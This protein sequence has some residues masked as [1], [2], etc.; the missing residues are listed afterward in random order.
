MEN[1]HENDATSIGCEAISKFAVSRGIFARSDLSTVQKL[2]ALAILDFTDRQCSGAFPGASKI[3]AAASCKRD[4]VFAAI[5]A[6]ERCGILIREGRGAGRSN[7][8]SFAAPE[9]WKPLASEKAPGSIGEPAPLKGTGLHSGRP[10]TGGATR[11]EREDG[12][13]PVLGDATKVIT[14]PSTKPGEAGRVQCEDSNTARVNP[15][16]GFTRAADVLGEAGASGAS[17]RMIGGLSDHAERTRTAPASNAP[18]LI[19]RDRHPEH[20]GAWFDWLGS[21]KREGVL[22]E[23]QAT[24]RRVMCGSVG[25]VTLPSPWPPGDERNASRSPRD[26]Q[27]VVIRSD[28]ERFDASDLPKQLEAYRTLHAKGIRDARGELRQ[29]LVDGCRWR[30]IEGALQ[31]LQSADGIRDPAAFVRAGARKRAGI[32]SREV[33]A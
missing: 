6:M 22:T 14:N 15:S 32:E 5:G 8:Y 10:A 25:V 7:S 28:L 26:P 31:R 17:L 3:A 9:T 30:D 16:P 12:T 18:V 27:P 24:W 11:H 1:S 4:T 2:V 33:A 29:L 13:R 23:E 19:N 21:R 20:F